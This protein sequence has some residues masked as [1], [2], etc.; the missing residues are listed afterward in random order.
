MPQAST[1]RLFL[2]PSTSH[3]PV[4]PALLFVAPAS[5]GTA[6]V[7]ILKRNAAKHFLIDRRL[8]KVCALEHKA[9]PDMTSK[10]NIGQKIIQVHNPHY[11]VTTA[12][13]L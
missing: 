13:T 6:Q 11:S 7:G 5:L 3:R 12:Q 10:N 1:K 9:Y 2:E 4:P 8:T